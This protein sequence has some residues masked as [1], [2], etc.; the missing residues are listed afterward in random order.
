VSDRTDQSSQQAAGPFAP[1]QPRPD[2][3][4]GPSHDIVWSEVGG[5]EAGDPGPDGD[6][7]GPI[8]GLSWSM[9]TRS[10]NA[11]EFAGHAPVRDDAAWE[12]PAW[13][14]QTW[15]SEIRANAP[16][17]FAEF[18]GER[19]ED[20]SLSREVEPRA[21]VEFQT[22]T[23]PSA[24]EPFAI[25]GS[26]EATGGPPF[27]VLAG[28]HAEPTAVASGRSRAAHEQATLET[29]PSAD[30]SLTPDRHGPAESD[31]PLSPGFATTT[32]TT[33]VIQRRAGEQPEPMPP[34]AAMPPMPREGN[35]QEPA[36]TPADT[37]AAELQNTGHSV[38]T[39]MAAMRGAQAPIA[40]SGTVPAP[41][42]TPG[43]SPI[44]PRDADPV[45]P[46]GVDGAAEP[47]AAA[48]SELPREHDSLLAKWRS[49]YFTQ[50]SS[51]RDLLAMWRSRY[52]QRQTR[53]P[54]RPVRAA[55]AD[56]S[57][58]ELLPDGLELTGAVAPDGLPAEPDIAVP[59]SRPQDNPSQEAEASPAADQ[60][61][62]LRS[63]PEASQPALA[64]LP[65]SE[66]AATIPRSEHRVQA[67]PYDVLAAAVQPVVGPSD[68][69]MAASRDGQEA[70]TS[71]IFAAVLGDD[72]E[73][74]L[75]RE[76]VSLSSGT[77]GN[78]AQDP[79]ATP[80]L[81]PDVTLKKLRQ[82]DQPRLPYE[83]S[84]S[85]A[86]PAASRSIGRLS[87]GLLG[88]RDPSRDEA[89]PELGITAPVERRLLHDNK[90]LKSVAAVTA[91]KQP[92]HGDY[93]PVSEP[94]AVPSAGSSRAASQRNA[95]RVGAPG[96]EPALSNSEAVAPE[97]TRRLTASREAETA[98]EDLRQTARYPAEGRPRVMTLRQI[99]TPLVHPDA[100]E[101]DRSVN[102]SP[103]QSP[104][105]ERKLE[106]AGGEGRSTVARDQP[107]PPPVPGPETVAFDSSAVGPPPAA[108]RPS[109]ARDLASRP[110]VDAA[111]L[112]SETSRRGPHLERPDKRRSDSAAP[113]RVS[114]GRITV[115]APAAPAQVQAFQRPRPTLSLNDYLERRRRSE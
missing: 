53:P 83:P 74:R 70:F 99:S 51:D 12:D 39:A 56:Q 93:P 103:A 34:N 61:I 115:E 2:S 106:S 11:G 30:A 26:G 23:A 45:L 80:A 60:T 112:P 89:G 107:P 95:P 1:V 79:E 55:E 86:K 81:A 15:A 44:T 42:T 68:T 32:P 7:L 59:D 62:Q 113:I 54:T 17:P 82:P 43:S 46:A 31:K 38:E 84:V 88:P 71:A 41:R 109:A 49:F 108:T 35:R 50:S 48:A 20:S 102:P 16:A 114:I 91:A 63:V 27:V 58:P 90:D 104:A 28:D 14:N 36:V 25:D 4:F 75:A 105:G 3:R 87:N 85:P 9:L 33:A 111:I 77:T 110:R 65:R 37:M 67:A 101:A 13:A 21:P 24:R 92:P 40:S 76:A 22:D 97:K 52:L 6:P 57:S 96:L 66:R 100:I 98:I 47:Y 19:A 64:S 5:L 18:P 69:P 78:T 73:P 29:D 94:R 8:A 72:I 10:L